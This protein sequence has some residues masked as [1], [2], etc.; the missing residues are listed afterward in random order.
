MTDAELGRALGRL[1]LDAVE[2]F[3]L[4]PSSPTLKAGLPL[5]SI[6]VGVLSRLARVALAWFPESLDP[7][8]RGRRT[9][10]PGSRL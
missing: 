2:R 10:D 4:K 6:G 9:T 8:L 7:S 5:S 3:S 1:L